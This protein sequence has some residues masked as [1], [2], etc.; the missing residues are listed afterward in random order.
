M[1]YSSASRR[2]AGAPFFFERPGVLFCTGEYSVA[3]RQATLERFT[4]ANQGLP[5][6]RVDMARRFVQPLEVHFRQVPDG[7][8]PS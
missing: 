4:L 3:R 7:N 5:Q 8:R 2:D 1:T 6:S